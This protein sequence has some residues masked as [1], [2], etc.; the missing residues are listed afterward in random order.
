[1]IKF[2][3]DDANLE[4]RVVSTN[5]VVKVVKGGSNFSF[6][7][8]VVIGNKNGIVGYGLGKA[9]EVADAISKG[10]EDAKKHLIKVPILRQTIPHESQAKFGGGKVLLKPAAPGTGVIAGAGVRAVLESAGVQNV[11]SK[12]MGSSNPHNVV[13]ATFKALAQLRSPGT[14][15]AQRGISLQKVFE[16]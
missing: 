15:A 11:L 10:F 8:V 12:S 7:V 2:G 4:K 13:K 5:R 14:V 6:S 1:M 3:T 9:A 16:G